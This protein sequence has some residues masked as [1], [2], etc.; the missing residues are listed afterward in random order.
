MDAVFKREMAI[1][2]GEFLRIFNAAFAGHIV[3]QA[4]DFIHM[5][6]DGARAKIHLNPEMK[7]KI[8]SLEWL[9]TEV[10][11]DLRGVPQQAAVRFLSRFERAFYKGGG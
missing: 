8:A 1:T 7:K 10:E 6:I 11:L 2:H 4:A 5:E 9:V 3:K